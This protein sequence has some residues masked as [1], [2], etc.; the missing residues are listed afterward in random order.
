MVNVIGVT[1]SCYLVERAD[2]YRV[3]VPATGEIVDE[4]VSERRSRSLIA[5]HNDEHP[6]ETA[7][8]VSYDAIVF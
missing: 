7:V 4:L 2:L 6:G 8:A 1:E 3:W 5:M